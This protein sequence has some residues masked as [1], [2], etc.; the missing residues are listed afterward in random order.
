LSLNLSALL[1]ARRIVILITGEAKWQVYAAADA[2]GP[3]EDM[4]VRAILRQRITPV[5]VTWSP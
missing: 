1:D 5:D 4:P 3:I 2:A